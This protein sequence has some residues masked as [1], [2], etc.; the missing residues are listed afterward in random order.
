MS[1]KRLTLCLTLS[2]LLSGCV[3][4]RYVGVQIT[5]TAPM[6]L[7]RVVVDGREVVMCRIEDGGNSA[8]AAHE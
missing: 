8:V 6:S 3:T 1:L 5:S 7:T 4:Q 2:C